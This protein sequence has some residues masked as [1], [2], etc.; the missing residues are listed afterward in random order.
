VTA[1]V[2]HRD[3]ASVT[4]TNRALVTDA[5]TKWVGGD[6]GRTAFGLIDESVVWTVTGSTPLSG[7]Y[8]SKA[9]VMEG[10]IVPIGRKLTGKVQAV[11]HAVLADGDRVAVEWSGTASRT[12]G[13]P[14]NQ[15]YC[16]VLRLAGGRIVEVTAYVDTQLLAEAWADE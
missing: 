5:W 14:Y 8:R 16:W 12:S 10:L 9:E 7:V 2:A 4:E 1:G 15:T 3:Q 11:L 13:K 6:R